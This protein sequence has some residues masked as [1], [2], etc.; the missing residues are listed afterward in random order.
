MRGGQYGRSKLKVSCSAPAGPGVRTC[1]RRGRV[2]VLSSAVLGLRS[3]LRIYKASGILPE[4]N[5]N[6]EPPF[7]FSFSSSGILHYETRPAL[8]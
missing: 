6:V 4:F 2:S 8:F 3:A 5:E 1:G 7:R